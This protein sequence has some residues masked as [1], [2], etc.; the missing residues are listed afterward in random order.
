MKTQGLSSK[1]TR[2]LFNAKHIFHVPSTSVY[3]QLKFVQ[4]V[5]HQDLHDFIYVPNSRH[6]NELNTNFVFKLYNKNIK[7]TVFPWPVCYN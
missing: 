7:K 6:S 2:L 3:I 4:K 5:P 1:S